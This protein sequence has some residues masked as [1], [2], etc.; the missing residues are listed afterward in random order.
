M[1]RSETLTGRDL[2]S[3][4]PTPLWHVIAIVAVFV[5]ATTLLVDGI[6]GLSFAVGAALVG[7]TWPSS[8]NPLSLERSRA[9]ARS[10]SGDPGCALGQP[11]LAPA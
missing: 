1:A 3:G 11:R 6:G 7:L 8:S 5:P 4:E 10:T 9:P 2:G